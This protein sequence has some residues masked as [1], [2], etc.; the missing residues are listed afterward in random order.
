[1]WLGAFD[2]SSLKEL[3]ELRII[4]IVERSL[5]R[6]RIDVVGFGDDVSAVRLK[7]DRLAVLKTDMLVGSTDVPPGMTMK[8]AARKAVVA[9]VSDLAAK[10]VR[11][12]AG[13]VALG[14]P[15]ALTKHDVQEIAKGLSSGAKEYRFP[16]LG[17]DTNESK[18]LVISIGLLGLIDRKKIILRSGAGI[19]DIVAVTGDFGSTSAGLRAILDRK[20]RPEKLPPGLARA[21]YHPHAELDIGLRLATTGAITASIDS[22]DGLAWSLHELSK[23][24]HIGIRLAMVPVSTAAREFAARYGYDPLDLALYGGEEY[25]LIVTVKRPLLR[26]AQRASRGRL[27]PIGVVTKRTEGVHLSMKGKDMKIEMK[28]WEHFRH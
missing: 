22:S 14:L 5:G 23:M 16:L 13:L 2:L 11:P 24:S 10:G 7:D 12:Y 19:G 6:S 21:V 28:G 3:G 9:N 25:R 20:I 27:R 18:D 8:Q 26:A 4:R 1:L 17:G 15:A